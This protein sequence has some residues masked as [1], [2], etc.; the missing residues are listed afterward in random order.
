MQVMGIDASELGVALVRNRLERNRTHGEVRCGDFFVPEQGERECCDLLVSFGVAE[1]FEPTA[2]CLR[3]FGQYVRPGGLLVTSIPNLASIY[4]PLQRWVHRPTYEKHVILDR[5]QLRQ[6]HLEAGFKIVSCSY[7][8]SVNFYL[9]NLSGHPRGLRRG[10]KRV[11]LGLLGRASRMAWWFES[12]GLQLP[13]TRWFSP[14]I[15]CVAEKSG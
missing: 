13:V 10:V 8:M 9:L 14:F 12:R 3:A 4:G 2:A 5:D 15:F 11:L 7:L 6:A 1:H